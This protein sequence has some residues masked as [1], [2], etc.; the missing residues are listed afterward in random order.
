MTKEKEKEMSCLTHE[1][2][3]GDHTHSSIHSRFPEDLLSVM[4][5]SKSVGHPI[6]APYTAKYIDIDGV[7]DLNVSS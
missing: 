1:R 4:S 2:F 7:I 6:P 3:K 5:F